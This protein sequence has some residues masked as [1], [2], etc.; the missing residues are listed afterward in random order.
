MI[1]LLFPL[2]MIGMYL[3]CWAVVAQL[4]LRS[5]IAEH[6]ATEPGKRNSSKTRD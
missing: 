1:E 6:T 2:A 4:H 5:E 3:C